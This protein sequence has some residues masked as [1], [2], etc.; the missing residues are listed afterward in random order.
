M[1]FPFH[2]NM[3]FVGFLFGLL[4]CSS[5]VSWLA[6]LKKCITFTQEVSTTVH[7]ALTTL[8]PLLVNEALNFLVILNIPM[9]LVYSK[10]SLCLQ[11]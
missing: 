3:N 2:L 6:T 11:Q 10:K 4:L 7:V 8:S 9:Q 5:L 1:I